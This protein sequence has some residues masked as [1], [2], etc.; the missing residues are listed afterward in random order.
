MIWVTWAQHRREALVSGLI[1]TVAA[2][3]L[4]ITGLSM[5]ADFEHSGAAA[6]TRT[7]GAAA[8]VFLTGSPCDPV[9]GSFTVGST[10]RFATPMLSGS[11]SGSRPSGSRSDATTLVRSGTPPTF[12]GRPVGR[13]HP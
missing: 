5:L 7:S 3:L 4:V 13:R 2:A 12:Y 10:A 9:I 1:L 8:G 11:S 6:C